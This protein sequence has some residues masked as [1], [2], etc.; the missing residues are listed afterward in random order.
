MSDH[1]RRASEGHKEH[2]RIAAGGLIADAGLK[3]PGIPDFL[4]S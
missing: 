1:V 2:S 3:R 4:V